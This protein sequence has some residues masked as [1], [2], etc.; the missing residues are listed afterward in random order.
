MPARVLI[1]EDEPSIAVSLE[2]LMR[3]CGYETLLVADGAEVLAA[4]ARFRPD[5]VILD[6][7]LPSVSGLEL[8]RGIRGDPRFA[9]A[10]ILMLTARGG[11]AEVDRGLGAGAD[12]YVVKPFSTHDLVDRVR[13]LL[14]ARADI[15]AAARARAEKP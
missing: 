11:A 10:K 8:S 3:G 12:D 15:P 9:G 2:F 14:E 4:M 7:M 6:V 1:A 13:A 5:L